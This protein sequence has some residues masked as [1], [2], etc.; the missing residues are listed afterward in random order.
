MIRAPPSAGR[1]GAEAVSSIEVDL[2]GKLMNDSQFDDFSKTRAWSILPRHRLKIL[3]AI[4]VSSVL[5]LIGAGEASARLCRGVERNCRSN[6]ECCDG[7]VCK[8]PPG[9]CTCPAENPNFCPSTGECLPPCS[10]GTT[11]NPKTCQCECPGDCSAN[12]CG[13]N[14]L[15]ICGESPVTGICV[16]AEK[17]SGSCTCFQPICFVGPACSSDADC[18]SGFACVN[19]ECCGF[20][21]CAALCGTPLDPALSTPSI[22]GN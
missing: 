15:A 9:K 7:L 18:A 6:A 5:S 11:F 20:S 13:V 4:A 14:P 19:S 10:G 2:G 21:F 16:C 3:A 22:W 8:V 1:R 17:T 12:P